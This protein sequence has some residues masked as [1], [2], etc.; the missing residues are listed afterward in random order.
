MQT[1]CCNYMSLPAYLPTFPETYAANKN[2]IV[3]KTI[4]P[5]H[6]WSLSFNEP[7][8]FWS[9]RSQQLSESRKQGLNIL[10][11][12]TDWSTQ[13]S[14]C[15]EFYI[16]F[17]YRIIEEK[18]AKLLYLKNECSELFF[19]SDIATYSMREFSGICITVYCIIPTCLRP[20][21]K[22]KTL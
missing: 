17:H 21:K 19:L 5:C 3:W 13:F 6:C 4:L 15:P 16:F 20:V 2:K 22:L 18:L 7:G 10:S 8:F 12:F 14:V 9:N 11:Q 1:K